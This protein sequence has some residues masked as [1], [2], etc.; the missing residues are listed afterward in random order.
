MKRGALDFKQETVGHFTVLRVSGAVDTEN[1]PELRKALQHLVKKRVRAVVLSLEGADRVDTSGVATLIE[2]AQMM[3]QYGGKM[4]VSGLN[5]QVANA[6][7][8]VQTE[9]MLSIFD[10]E[11]EALAALGTG[12]SEEQEAGSSATPSSDAEPG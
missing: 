1:S 2:C 9:R 5:E 4:L 10:T 3:S 6:F 12:L 11:A 7:A 8:L